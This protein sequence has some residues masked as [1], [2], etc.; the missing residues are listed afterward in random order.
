[1]LESWGGQ[2]G[3]ASVQCAMAL[4]A[5]RGPLVGL[6]G[7]HKQGTRQRVPTARGLPALA[8]APALPYRGVLSRRSVVMTAG[9]DNDST[10]QEGAHAQGQLCCLPIMW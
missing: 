7:A 10:W 6:Y 4:T 8:L 1:M 2:A 5:V 9:R 3:I